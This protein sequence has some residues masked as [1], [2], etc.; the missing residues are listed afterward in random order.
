MNG[1]TKHSAYLREA[2]WLG[3]PEVQK[4]L[5]LLSPDGEETRCVGGCVRDTLAGSVASNADSDLEVDMATTLTPDAVMNILENAGIRVVATGLAYGT[6]TAIFPTDAAAPS[7][8]SKKYEITTLR[9][10]IKGDGRHAEVMFGRDWHIDAA[11]RDLTINAIYV[12]R[13]GAIFDPTESG[14]ADVAAGR[15]RFI[16]EPAQRIKEDY[17]RILRFVR[18]YF[19]ISP[20]TAPDAP[21][22]EAIK[23]AVPHIA[24]LSGERRQ[25]EFLKILGLDEADNAVR[26]IDEMGALHVT[27]G[28]DGNWQHTRL[29]ALL[30]FAGSASAHADRLLRLAALMPDTAAA[31]AVAAALRLSRQRAQRLHKA[32]DHPGVDLMRRPTYWLHYNGAATVRDQSLMA[33]ASGNITDTDAKNLLAL[34]DS[35]APRLFPLGGADMAALGVKHGPQ[36]GA[37]LGALETWWVENGFPSD[38]ALRD[39]LARRVSVKCDPPT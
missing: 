13:Y 16:G 6:V 11:R 31:D 25:D 4:L 10:D 29:S 8:G 24:Q 34:A 3:V 32:V 1:A 2:T 37:M 39:E 19:Q 30:G 36:M 17:L 7:G 14:I 26:F 33:C 23:A 18:F 38:S 22:V 28:V 21:T 20:D 5:A 9:H 27:L 12:D 35:W 15:V